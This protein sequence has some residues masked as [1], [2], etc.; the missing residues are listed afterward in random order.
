M[1]R[2]GVL[3]DDMFED[4]E[5]VKPA[6][7]FKDAGHGLVNIGVKMGAVT[8]AKTGV[9]VEIDKTASEVRPDDFDAIFIP[10]GYSPDRL[11]S[12]DEVVNFVKQFGATDKPIFFICHGA[13]LLITA[14]LLK[15]RRVTGWKSIIQ[16]I[17]NA[18]AEYADQEVVVDRNFVSSRSPA[19]IPAFTKDSL[20]KL[21]KISV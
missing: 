17:K 12:N 19:D 15:G 7:A 11:R 6:K 16:D 1:A 9:K 8:G 5:Y 2:V 14:G 10:G 3:I 4:S 20:I 21:K 13:Q 18:G